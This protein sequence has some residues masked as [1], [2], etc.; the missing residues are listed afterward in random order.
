MGFKDDPFKTQPITAYTLELY[1]G[2]TEK[3]MTRKNTAS[4]MKET[5]HEAMVFTY[6]EKT[7]ITDFANTGEIFKGIMYGSKN[8]RTT[9]NNI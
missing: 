1:T 3:H 2:N 4:I 5:P 9:V 8:R 7:F 6:Y